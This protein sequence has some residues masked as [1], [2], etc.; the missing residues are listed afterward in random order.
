MDLDLHLKIL[1]IASGE[2]PLG[3]SLD[4]DLNLLIPKFEALSY[5]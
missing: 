1:G 4:F 5:L 2:A 3:H